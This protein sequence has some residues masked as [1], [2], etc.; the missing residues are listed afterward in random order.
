MVVDFSLAGET[1]VAIFKRGSAAP[2]NLARPANAGDEE[3]AQ[4]PAE[5]GPARS[6]EVAPLAPLKNDTVFSW[7]HLDYS[8][9]IPGGQ[10]RQLLN[11]ISGYVVPGKLT[12]LMGESGAGKVSITR[13]DYLVLY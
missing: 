8:V 7:Q 5:S 6:K 13:Y 9:P 11:D 4:P 1:V 2:E 12:A 10:Q 3:K